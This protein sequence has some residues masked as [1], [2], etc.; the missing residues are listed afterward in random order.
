MDNQIRL[1]YM[2]SFIHKEEAEAYREEFFNT[3]VGDILDGKLVIIEDQILEI[4][5]K[6]MV[7]IMAENSQLELELN[8]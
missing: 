5:T 3:W 6:F 4:N 8:G 1:S 2:G 7:R